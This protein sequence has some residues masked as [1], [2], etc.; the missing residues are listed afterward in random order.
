MN[1]YKNPW[2]KTLN[3]PKPEYYE[4]NAPQVGEHRGVVVYKLFT[5]GYDFVLG[6]VCITQRA[7]ISEYKKAIDELLDGESFCS[8][9][10]AAHLKSL[11]HTPT[12]YD[13][14]Q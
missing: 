8:D 2:H 7:G 5:H 4:N 13:G 1:R 11:G 6:G 9:E 3:V 12:T 10:V 14:E